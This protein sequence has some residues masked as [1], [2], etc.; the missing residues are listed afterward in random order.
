M[1]TYHGNKAKKDNKSDK[2]CPIDFF[3]AIDQDTFMREYHKYLEM[4]FSRPEMR[5]RVAC[6][7]E[8]S[9][10]ILGF[11]VFSGPLLHFVFVKPD[12][13]HIGLGNDLVPDNIGIVTGFTRVGDIIRRKRG[14]GFNPWL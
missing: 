9:D 13:R 8:E 14:W 3:S 7:V 2:Q 6:L 5:I 10:V 12:W 11:S 1:G 4:L